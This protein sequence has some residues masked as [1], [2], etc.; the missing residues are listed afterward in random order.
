M[1][2]FAQ[3]TAFRSSAQFPDFKVTSQLLPGQ[4]LVFDSKLRAFINKDA[5]SIISLTQLGPP[6]V[7]AVTSGTN[8]GS[9]VEVFSDIVLD[10]IQFRTLIG[11]DGI[12]ITQTTEEIFI[13]NDVFTD[14]CISVPSNFKIEIDNDNTTD[15]SARFEL[16]TNKHAA[17]I[18]L[19]P[20]T[21]NASELDITTVTD[22][23]GTDPGQYVSATVDFAALGFEVGMCLRATGTTE[24]DGVF[25]IASI[26]TTTNTNDTITITI[27]FPDDTDDGAQ[28]ATTLEAVFF[29]FLTNK[30]FKSAGADFVAAGFVPGQTIQI[31]GTPAGA[32][33][34][35]LATYLTGETVVIDSTPVI[36]STGGSVSVAGAD[37]ATYTKTNDIVINGS[38]IV[39]ST[40]TTVADA[41]TDITAAIIPGVSA[42]DVGGALVITSTVPLILAEGAGTALADLGFTPGSFPLRSTVDDAVIDINA[43]GITGISA[44]KVSD[45]LRILSTNQSI[46]LAEGTGTAL[47]DLGLTAG[48]FT[49]GG[50]LD[51]T[52]TIASL[53]TDTITIVE[54]FSG[55]FPQCVV[56][57]INVKTVPSETL[58]TG[59]WVNE[60]GQMQAKDTTIMGDL[61]VTGDTNIDGDLFIGS[62]NILDLINTTTPIS[63]TDGLLVQISPGVI[64]GR[65]IDVTAG[66]TIIREDG[67]SGNPT[68]GVEDFDLTFTGD[69]TGTNTVTTLTNTSI[70]LTLASVVAPGTFNEVT[71]DAKGRVIS[72]T[73]VAL[74]FQPLDSDLTTLSGGLVSPG[75]VV[76][77][78]TDYVDR[79]LVGT[80]DQITLTEPAAT[81]GNTTIALADNPILPGIES[82][83]VPRGFTGDRPT[84][85]VDG[86]VRYNTT[87][88]LFEGHISGSW[89][90]FIQGS[91]GDFLPI[92]GGTMTGDIVMDDNNITFTTGLVD[93]RNVSADGTVL[94]SINSGAGIKVQTG[95]GTFANRQIEPG[96]DGPIEIINGDGIFGNMIIDINM[97]PTTELEI[98]E[99]VDDN[100]D[101]LLLH[102]TSQGGIRKVNP[103]FL[104]KHDAFRYFMAQI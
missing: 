27:H 37:G 18:I 30:L 20:V 8:L 97:L 102:D 29:K 80:A 35:P 67:I 93:G 43:A 73:T 9:G 63:A 56:G 64:E 46:I 104:N 60:C 11:D 103:A 41:V 62:F 50:V 39:L 101:Y 4:I 48:T 45:A 57:N 7:G 76:W 15:C 81:A 72:G 59:W 88:D 71:V 21:Y 98:G 99:V 79:T 94:D 77:N 86:M 17:Q 2:I 32:V 47:D 44:L 49:D 36:L 54:V 26:D 100:N 34:D 78:G 84:V 3:R 75:Y 92:I 68:I 40:G 65:E 31:S 55:I 24:Q 33:G 69:A 19:T 13:S 6:P 51:D 70:A 38:S 74:S 10:D 1:A 5:S 61:T 95:A 53:T 16:F 14:A 12:T 82:V 66:L 89:E 58:S 87:D 96:P 90:P 52:Y 83:T 23:G 85:S 22:P 25:E 42:A 91:A 28:P